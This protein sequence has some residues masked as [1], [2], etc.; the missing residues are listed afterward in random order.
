VR[1]LVSHP[2]GNEF[3]REAINGFYSAGCLHAIYTSVASFPGTLSHRL[4]SVKK[5]SDIRRRTLPAAFKKITHTHPVKEWGRLLAVKAGKKKLVQHET[6]IFSADAVYKSLDKY[7]AKNLAKEKQQGVTA[8]YAYEDGAYHS[9]RKAVEL[10]MQRLYDLPIGHWRYMRSLL[11]EEKELNPGWANTLEGLKDS[12]EKL[13]RKDEEIALADK[14]FVASS[15]TMNSLKAYPG[16]LAPVS[17]IPYGF[18]P[19]TEKNYRNIG[20]SQ[21]IKLLFVGGLSQRKGLS[22][23]FKAVEGLD[24]NLE[25]TVVGRLPQISCAPLHRELCK[26]KH[27]SSLPH[28]KIL[29]LMHEQ[30]VLIFPSLFEG[31]GQV[32]TEAMAQ[33]TPVITTERTAGADLIQHGE[34]GWLVKAGSAEAIKN[35]LQEI[36]NKPGLIEQA[37]RKAL[38]TAKKRPWSVYRKELV[39][40]AFS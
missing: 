16:T 13:E 12:A 40:A 32:I 28:E 18:P 30:D 10:N 24:A 25:L 27:I 33:G 34:N 36:T 11:K 6:G 39:E 2:T 8:I 17:V 4:G 3:F 35:V 26:H 21:K 5:L 19:A 15:F 20:P 7:V 22:Y 1:I 23:L 9:F 37:G 31:F 29:R 38:D 14:I